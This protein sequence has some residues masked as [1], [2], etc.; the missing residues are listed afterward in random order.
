MSAQYQVRKIE[1]AVA[2]WDFTL[3]EDGTTIDEL[4]EFLRGIA[5]KWC[6]QLEQGAQTGYLHYQ[7]RV[8]LKVRSRSPKKFKDIW[9]TPTSNACKKDDFYVTK[10]E[11]R[12]DGPWKDSQEEERIPWQLMDIKELYPWQQ[13]IIDLALIR[14]KRSIHVIIDHDGCIG[15]T[16]LSQ[17]MCVRKIA[18]PLPPMNDF[19]DIC[20]AAMDLEERPAYL[21][22]MP[23]AIKQDKLNQLYAG[24]EYIKSGYIFDDRYKFECKIIDC[25]NLFVFTNT[26]PDLTYV[27]K[28]RWK[29]W[30]VVQG[31]LVPYEPVLEPESRAAVMRNYALP[32][33]PKP[34]LETPNG[35]RV[36][37]ASAITLVRP[38][39]VE[40]APT[41]IR[42]VIT[43]RTDERP[44]VRSLRPQQY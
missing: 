39:A 11:T 19:K 27:S 36:D 20:R 15:K 1:N 42:P 31:Q 22:D 14:D 43:L 30:K 16:T 44:P 5:K 21:I 35:D 25:P 40:T 26:K 24:I 12:V 41:I 37:R 8:S 13:S 23:R 29:L 28:D 6:F 34:I 2:V 32:E 33:S 17:I 18:W 4:K 3:K 38:A 10:E 9:W 7:G